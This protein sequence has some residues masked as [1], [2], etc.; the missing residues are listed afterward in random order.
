MLVEK[1][2]VSAA[3]QAEVRA[4][5]LN[6]LRRLHEGMLVRYGLRPSE[7]K[8]WQGGCSG[9]DM[10]GEIALAIE[11]M[12]ADIVDIGKTIHLHQILGESVG[13]AG[14]VAYGFCTDGPQCEISV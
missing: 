13:M 8:I 14:E 1:V 5:I 10:M 11:E 6:E 4:L 9:D 2:S 7:W 3:Q 12:G